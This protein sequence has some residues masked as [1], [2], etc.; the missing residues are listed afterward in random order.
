[1]TYIMLVI[2]IMVDYV[3][4]DFPKKNITICP[5]TLS[6]GWILKLWKQFG[7]TKIFNKKCDV[8]HF[9]FKIKKTRNFLFFMDNIMI[10]WYIFIIQIKLC[11]LW[12]PLIFELCNKHLNE[13][14]LA[15]V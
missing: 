14:L 12:H 7:S 15:L 8:F 4:Y 6:M 1:M 13:W 11:N 3:F 2:D 9:T 10:V 5:K